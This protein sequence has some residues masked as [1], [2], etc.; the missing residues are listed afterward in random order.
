M[1]STRLPGKTL[2]EVEGKPLLQHLLERLRASEYLDKTVIATTDLP[3]D[4]SIEN[5]CI[6]NKVPCFRGSSDDVLE[7][8]TE[9]YLAHG[10]D[11][12]VVVYGDGP[13]IDPEI[14]DQ[15]IQVYQAS[16][17]FDFVGNDLITTYPGGMEVEVFSIDAICQ[18][19]LLC[20][21]KSIR[22]HGTLFLRLNPNL[23]RIH[24][25]EAE[26]ALRRPDLSLEVDTEED[27][28]VFERVAKHLKDTESFSLHEIIRFVDINN[29]PTLNQ[30][31]TSRWKQYRTK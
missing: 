12:G 27:L 22:E 6:A 19:R 20:T 8:I 30:H 14:I 13:L 23:F 18:A 31:I 10:A 24:N 29:L 15:T 11:T 21:N 25:V 4:D 17:S 9:A 1:G 16:D 3:H 26:G 28:M 2:V 5:Y 7:R